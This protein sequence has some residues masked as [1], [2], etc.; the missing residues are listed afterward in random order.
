MLPEKSMLI[1]AMLI[2]AM[3]HPPQVTLGSRVD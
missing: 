2:I 1:V 3:C